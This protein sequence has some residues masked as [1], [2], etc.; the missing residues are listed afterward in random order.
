[1]SSQRRHQDY[2]IGWICPLEVE[3]TAALL[4]LDET[5]DR[6]TQQPADQNVYTLG[7][8][9]GHNIVIAGLHQPGNS[10]AATVVT[11]MR[12]TFPSIHYVLLVGIGGGV[13]VRTESDWV[14]LGD[15]VV[16]KPIG[17][18]P[19]V[20]QYDTGKAEVGQ[21]KRIGALPPPPVVLLQA[22][23]D[24]AV[25]RALLKTQD[26][27]ISKCLQRIPSDIPALEKYL[28]PGSAKDRLYHN[29]YIH[30]QPGIPCD[31]CKCDLA[32]LRLRDGPGKASP[33]YVRV[34][35]GVIASGGMVIKD[36]NKRDEL[37]GKYG[38]LC[39]ETEA[40]GILADLPALVIR[41]I[42][43]YCDSHK[44]DQ[45]HGYAAATAAAYARQ[46]ILHTP[47]YSNL[48]STPFDNK[49]VN[50][51]SPSLIIPW[52]QLF[53][54]MQT[55]QLTASSLL[56][57]VNDQRKELAAWIA[58]SRPQFKRWATSTL[59]VSKVLWIR[60]GPGC[61]KTVLTASIIQHVTTYFF[62]RHEDERK[63]DPNEIARSWVRQIVNKMDD[64]V[65]IAYPLCEKNKSRAA[66]VTEVWEILYQICHGMDNCM[67]FLDGLDE[68]VM[69][70]GPWHQDKAS[71]L[72]H[73]WSTV[74]GTT[75]RVLI[76][77]RTRQDA[78][79]LLEYNIAT[80]DTAQDI[81]DYSTSVVNERL[82]ISKDVAH[83]CGGM[84]LWVR[85]MGKQLS[86]G[87]NKNQT[88]QREM[89]SILNLG[90]D[91]KLRAIG[92]LRWTYFAA[93][94][95]T[96][97]ELTEALLT[98]ATSLTTYPFDEMPDTWDEYYSLV[99]IRGSSASSITN[100]TV[101]FI[102]T[103]VKEFLS[104][105]SAAKEHE[106]LARTC[107][108]Y[109]CFDEITVD[110][111]YDLDV[112]Q[113]KKEMFRFLEYASLFW[114][115]HFIRVLL[116]PSS[117]RWI[118]WS[119][120]VSQKL[121]PV[122][123]LHA[124]EEDNRPTPLHI[125]SC[126]GLLDTM[127]WLLSLGS[128]IDATA[129]RFGS[130][131]HSAAGR[132]QKNANRPG[133]LYGYPI[134]AAAAAAK[135]DSLKSAE[136][137]HILLEAG[138]DISCRDQTGRKGSAI[139][140]QNGA[141]VDVRDDHERTPLF[142][143]I[144]NG[145]KASTIDVDSQTPLFAAIQNGHTSIVETLTQYDIDVRTQD[146]AG[147]TPLHIAV[148]LGHE[149]IVNI[150][151]RHGADA[152]AA[153][154]NGMTP[155][156]FAAL[157]GNN[158]IL[159]DLIQHQGQVN[160]KTSLAAW[161]PLHAAACGK[162]EQATTV[163]LLLDNGAEVDAADSHGNTP[164]FYAAGNGL[165]A[166]IE[167]LIRYNA[168]INATQEQGLTPIYAAL[169]GVQPLALETL[170]K[171]GGRNLIG[172]ECV[173]LRGYTPLMIAILI[174]EFRPLVQTLVRAGMWV[175]SRDNAGL[176]PLHL[177][178]LLGDVGILE[179]LLQNDAA[180]NVMT[181]KGWTP[182]HLAVS[183]GKE[184]IVQLLLDNNADVN[185]GNDEITPIYIA[186][187]NRDAL[188]T[189]RLVRY[190]AEADHGPEFG[191]EFLAYANHWGHDRIVKLMVEHLLSKDAVD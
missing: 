112:L 66:T 25:K 167:T 113:N 62:C 104:Q 30:K 153:D 116:D 36:A 60:G 81:I 186:I 46:L 47:T 117:T 50:T 139:L 187:D 171:Y 33:E 48:R 53:E 74:S 160:R 84:F 97:R 148:K 5:H 182:L 135:Y 141:T 143:L 15:V 38:I 59:E 39:F 41:G 127:E 156:F 26:D 154:K 77:S 100:H 120:I 75:A 119:E 170:V 106:L 51:A 32:R 67:L 72:A 180:V 21:F 20:V 138:A 54:Q 88:Y 87:L 129:G 6:L 52:V 68:C 158:A 58:L 9:A 11:Q 131:L 132:G 44:N 134:V 107:L 28:H 122:S 94:P 99:D 105:T 63:Q 43:D 8:I 168:Q 177:A 40:A 69:S 34:H 71:F 55:L 172:D 137:V 2:A 31:E 115:A 166:T 103:S 178:T 1:M 61:G 149:Q 49:V 130:A 111:P 37:A 78:I 164:L 82:G 133:G 155:V 83:K 76:S 45:W 7:S 57:S 70:G 114:Y 24:M 90:V 184:D 185:A 124:T 12:N 142:L 169:A 89:Q 118:L 22:A 19:G 191:P 95:L 29:D 126:M 165:P 93:R 188:I 102:H 23:Q 151:L 140:L 179:L 80:E 64:A 96:V 157:D 17:E 35:R 190:G 18:Y 98:E 109:L 162:R 181:D 175:N 147:L 125:A 121:W 150:L 183:E 152:N 161:T 189:R 159:Q 4:M 173:T 91:E 128:D 146:N 79:A 14:R 101:H 13:P 163:Q 65:N 92:I 86:P 136:I 16:S 85:L 176:A 123:I 144:K 108:T 3:Q 110:D 56:P 27:P 73:L 174:E 42:A 145:A 10:P